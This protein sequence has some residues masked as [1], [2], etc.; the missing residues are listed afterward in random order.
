MGGQIIILPFLLPSN[1]SRSPPRPTC[2]GGILLVSEFTNLLDYF[3]TPKSKKSS[4]GSF[5]P[6][7]ICIP[8][9]IRISG[10]IKSGSVGSAYPTLLFEFAHRHEGWEKLKRDARLRAFAAPMTSKYSCFCQGTIYTSDFQAPTGVGMNIVKS[11]AKLPVY[12]SSC[13]CFGNYLGSFGVALG[14]RRF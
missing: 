12:S 3:H 8:P 9:A 7:D 14:Y 6:R 10:T 5:T 2:S 4:D 13:L 1:Y 11:M